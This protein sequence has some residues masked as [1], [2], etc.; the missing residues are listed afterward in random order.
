MSKMKMHGKRYSDVEQSLFS[1]VIIM[2]LPVKLNKNKCLLELTQESVIRNKYNV[3]RPR[4]IYMI[5]VCEECCMCRY[6][7]ITVGKKE[8]HGSRIDP[9]PFVLFEI[10]LTHYIRALRGIKAQC[11]WLTTHSLTHYY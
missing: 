2:L 7:R 1:L 5:D 9:S 6:V 4:G 3:I 11:N 8:Y 10:I